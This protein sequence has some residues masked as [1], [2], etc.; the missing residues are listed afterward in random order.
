MLRFCRCILNVKA[1]TSNIMVYG[2]CGI[3]PPSIYCNVSAM[4]YINRLHHMPNDSIVKQVYNELAKLHQLGFTTWVTHVSK[5]VDSYL[6]DIDCSPAEFKSECKRTVGNR[7][8]NM[9]T[10]QVQNIHSNPILRTYCN[11][12]CNFGMETYLDAIKNYKYRVAMSQLRTISHTLAIEYGRYT[13]P[14]TKI[15]D[16]KCSSCHILEDERHFLIECNINQADRENLFSKLTHIAPNFIIWMTKKNLFSSCATKTNKYLHGLE[17]SYINLS[18]IELNTYH[19]YNAVCIFITLPESILGVYQF[20]CVDACIPIQYKC[21]DTNELHFYR[22]LYFRDFTSR[23]ISYR[24]VY[25]I[26]IGAGYIH[27]Y[28]Y[29]CVFIYVY[30]YIYMFMCLRMHVTMYTWLYVCFLCVLILCMLILWFFFY[31]WLLGQ[32]WPNKEVQTKNMIGS[33]DIGG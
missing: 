13:R 16:R 1:T 20:S 8:I 32:R 10:E 22:I 7:F 12:K 9:W 2:E 33:P 15:E 19:R 30:V 5:M 11:M 17:N 21:I 28:A 31:L 25:F 4:C 29:I 24:I 3:L 14:K 18:T 6:L 26:L 27:I 23:Y